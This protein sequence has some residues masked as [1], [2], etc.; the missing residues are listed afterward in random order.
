MKAVGTERDPSQAAK[1]WT[2]GEAEGVISLPSAP[3][4]LDTAC[5]DL[6]RMLFTGTYEI[7]TPSCP[8]AQVRKPGLRDTGEVA[9]IC[10]VGD[11]AK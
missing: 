8:H 4:V 1:M 9:K 5:Q 6:T 2:K 7:D 10:T 11:M 3:D